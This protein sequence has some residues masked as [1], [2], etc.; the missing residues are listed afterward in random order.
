MG[1]FGIPRPHRSGHAFGESSSGSP[2]NTASNTA[3][4]ASA[5]PAV[6]KGLQWNAATDRYAASI[7]GWPIQRVLARL[8][9]QTGW[10]VWIEDGIETQIR[11][12]FRNLPAREA[13][14]R[15]LGELNYSL[16]T[17][18]NGRRE[19]KVFATHARS[20]TREIVAD[21]GEGV[22]PNELIIRSKSGSPSI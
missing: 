3:A 11:A 8:S 17:S 21:E 1:G 7:P 16:T 19:L 12:Q 10:R 9:G 14:P 4:I 5:A 6:R 22:I 13:L 15:I 2:S 20:S 18:T